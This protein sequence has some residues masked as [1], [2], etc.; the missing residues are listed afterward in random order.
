M[1]LSK[2]DALIKKGTDN[3]CGS[4]FRPRLGNLCNLLTQPLL[5]ATVRKI[6]C[7]IGPCFEPVKADHNSAHLRLSD[8]GKRRC[9]EGRLFDRSKPDL[10]SGFI[11]SLNRQLSS[12]ASVC[13][14]QQWALCNRAGWR[15]AWFSPT[16]PHG[17]TRRDMRSW[18]CR[19]LQDEPWAFTQRLG[20]DETICPTVAYMADSL[21]ATS[22]QQN[23]SDRS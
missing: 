17:L 6:A 19:C 20:V 4:P 2:D 23:A 11:R 10:L 8:A 15:S 16:D 7:G 9:H 18:K 13:R 3:A 14:W 12:F 22:I 1:L 5:N 21:G